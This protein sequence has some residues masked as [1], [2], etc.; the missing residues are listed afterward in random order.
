MARTS[1]RRNLEAGRA[2]VLIIDVINDFSFESGDRLLRNFRPCVP[3]IRK[4]LATARRRRV[5]VLYVNDNFRRWRDSLPEIM[6][7]ATRAG[8]DGVDV[9]TALAPQ[10][11]DYFILKPRHSGFLGTP[12]EALLGALR[13]RSLVLAGVA[14][15]SCVLFTA[16]DA[17]MRGYRV[18][19]GSDGV[20]ATTKTRHDNALAVMRASFAAATPRLRDIH[21]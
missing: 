14:T 9:V 18:V 17:H 3:R 21:L 6:R 11:T 19:V 16:C 13:I 20:A 2:A 5:P 8:L 10:P 15:D 1:R 7:R 12:L 4:F